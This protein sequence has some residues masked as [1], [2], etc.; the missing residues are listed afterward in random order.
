MYM[1]QFLK[2]EET[3]FLAYKVDIF[4]FEMSTIWQIYN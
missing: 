4:Y 3:T 2:A 1:Q